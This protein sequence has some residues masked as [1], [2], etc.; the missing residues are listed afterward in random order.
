MNPFVPGGYSENSAL[1][2]HP[3]LCIMT[4]KSRCVEEQCFVNYFLMSL[5]VVV[6][7]FKKSIYLLLIIE[8]IGIRSMNIKEI[9]TW[10]NDYY[11]YFCVFSS[12]V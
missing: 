9:H 4:L 7:V 10:R 3:S 11:K 6:L 2:G 8:N 5:F 1:P 12:N